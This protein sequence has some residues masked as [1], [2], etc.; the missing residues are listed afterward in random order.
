MEFPVS[1]FWKHL[2][3]SSPRDAQHMEVSHAFQI[4]IFHEINQPAGVGIPPFV[5]KPHT[6]NIISENQ[7]FVWWLHT[8]K[9]FCM[10]L[11][12]IYMDSTCLQ[13]SELH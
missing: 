10:I 9:L 5:G 11:I 12:D 13:C 2:E 8:L 3:L 4:W 6:S 1:P 7:D